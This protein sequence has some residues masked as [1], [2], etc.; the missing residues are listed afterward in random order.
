MRRMIVVLLVMT[1]AA[2]GGKN[3]NKRTDKTPSPED[4]APA[5]TLSPV[6]VDLQQ[7][8]EALRGSQQAISQIWDQLAANQEVQCG[9]Y[10]DVLSP[11]SISAAGDPAN[12]PLADLLRSAANDLN[13]ALSVWKAECANPRQMPPPDVIDEGRLA[14]RAAG[15]ALNEAEPL[16]AGVQ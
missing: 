12:Q 15:D 2:C 10:P 7:D 1:L 4:L 11:E 8:F 3:T 6:L 5:A 13:H 16:L 14:A 9:N